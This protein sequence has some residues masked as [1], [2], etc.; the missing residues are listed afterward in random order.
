VDAVTFHLSAPSI[1]ALF[2]HHQLTLKKR[3]PRWL[4]CLDEYRRKLHLQTTSAALFSQP[5][6]VD[7]LRGP[8][9]VAVM[10]PQ[11]I[12]NVPAFKSRD[13]LSLQSLE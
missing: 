11:E 3:L 8:G 12:L 4:E 5:P 13:R 1:V 9:N 7:C 6:V 2:E 10:R